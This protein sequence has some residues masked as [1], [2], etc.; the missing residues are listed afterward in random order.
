MSYH[1]NIIVQ[2]FYSGPVFIG[3]SV[4]RLTQRTQTFEPK[5]IV[6]VLLAF[7]GADHSITLT[8]CDFISYRYIRY[9]VNQLLAFM[10]EPTPACIG[11]AG[12]VDHTDVPI[13]GGEVIIYSLHYLISSKYSLKCFLFF[14]LNIG[15]LHN[16]ILLFFSKFLKYGFCFTWF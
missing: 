14:I 6:H 3:F 10:G 11:S 16:F 13:Q 9:R 2:F 7:P 1:R 15:E 4:S 5:F 12:M 8:H